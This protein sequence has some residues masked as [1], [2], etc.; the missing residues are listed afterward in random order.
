MAVLFHIK[1]VAIVMLE[2]VRWLRRFSAESC[3]LNLG[4]QYHH[5]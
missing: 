3:I 4:P 5:T 1:T 2:N